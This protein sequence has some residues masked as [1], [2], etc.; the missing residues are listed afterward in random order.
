MANEGQSA[1]QRIQENARRPQEPVSSHIL[2]L[3]TSCSPPQQSPAKRIFQPSRHVETPIIR[4]GNDQQNTAQRIHKNAAAP[5]ERVGSHF[6]E[7]SYELLPPAI[8]GKMDFSTYESGV[9]KLASPEWQTISRT[10]LSASTRTQG[11]RQH[12]LIRTFSQL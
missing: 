12:A 9:L 5:P 2:I 10:P 3:C 4:M 11:R 8:P 7:T 1:A 6:F